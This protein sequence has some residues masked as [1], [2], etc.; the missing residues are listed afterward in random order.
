[1]ACET[2]TKE[3][4]YDLMKKCA[5]IV[6][7]HLIIHSVKLIVTFGVISAIFSDWDEKSRREGNYTISFEGSEIEFE[8]PH[9][10]PHSEGAMNPDEDMEMIMIVIGALIVAGFAVSVLAFC[11]CCGCV[12]FTYNRLYVNLKEEEMITFF[13]KN[14]TKS[15]A[16]N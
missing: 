5:W 3:C 10:G 2:Q 15:I 8:R 1:M 7:A 14:Q 6:L 9:A 4:S 13:T 16:V 11:C 12:F